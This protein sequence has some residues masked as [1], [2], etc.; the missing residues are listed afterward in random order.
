MQAVSDGPRWMLRF[1]P[2]ERLPDSLAEFARRNQVEA[3]A[4]AMGI[5][6][7]VEAKVGFWNGSEYVPRSLPTPVEVVSLSG[8]IAQADGEPS[9]HLHAVLGTPD[10]G[11]V[12][13]HLLSGTVGLLVEMLV[14]VFP[15]RRFG[16]PFDES[17]GLR[18]LDLEPPP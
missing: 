11:A 5:G 4:V 18:R 17:L 2:G 12:S 16:R 10:H 14:I 15:G 9:I 8:S 7:F 3:A 1:V 13:G 6:Q